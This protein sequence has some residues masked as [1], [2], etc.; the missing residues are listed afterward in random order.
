MASKTDVI[1][2]LLSRM[3]LA[4]KIGQLNLVTPG[5]ETLTGSVVNTGVAE[6][7]KAGRIGSIFGVKSPAAVRALQ[8]LALQSRLAIPLMF[9]E[10]VVHGH[11]TIFPIPIG[12]AATWNLSLIEET[13]RIAAV[14]AT[15]GGIDQVYAPVVD[16]C[17]DPR[18]GRMAESPGE[19]P[20]LASRYA[21]AMV[22]GFQ[23]DDLS[24]PDATMACLKHFAAYGAAAAGRDYAGADMSPMRL[25]DVYLPPFKAGVEAGAGSIMAGF[26]TLNGVPMHANRVLIEEV[27][28]G[29]FGF[30]GLVVSDY[31]GVDELMGHQMAASH[32]EA[33]RAAV[34]AGVD[35]DMV[36]ESYLNTLQASVEAGLLDA[37]LIEA[38]CRRVLEAKAKLGLFDDP[39]RRLKAGEPPAEL[40][41]AH[42]AVARRAAADA[43]VL[44]KNEG[45]VLPLS[46]SAKVALVGPLTNDRVNMNGTWAVSGRSSDAVT[47]L[48]GFL[49][50]IGQGGGIVCARGC[51]IVDDP[52]LA[53]RL[54]VHDRRD[55]SVSIDPRTADVLIAEAIA[56]AEAA[57]V[58]VAVLGESKEYSGESSSRADLRLSAGQRRLVADLKQTGKPLVLVILAGRALVITEEAATADAVVYAWFGGT[59]TGHGLADLLYG[60]AEPAGRLP[61]TLPFHEGQVP[62]AYGEPKTGRPYTGRFEKFRTGYLDLPDGPE[63][64]DGLFPFGFGLSYSAVRYGPVTADRTSLSGDADRAVIS[65]EVRNDG[66]RPAVDVV[67]LYVGAPVSPISRPSRR[68]VQFE[69]LVL[70]P[71][72]ARTVS[73]A[74][75]AADLATSVAEHVAD[76]RRDWHGGAFRVFL[77]ANSRA[78]QGVDLIWT[79]DGAVAV[80]S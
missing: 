40:P 47:I 65:C 54:N 4:E 43:C 37:S 67:Q 16:V 69:R 74:I 58:V 66:D 42:R 48:D 52:V 34:K 25:H 72:E 56:A 26:N 45:G 44:L 18:W 39:Y 57:D 59:E 51:N 9:A 46:R 2:D 23:G 32:A 41:S 21:E 62:I 7:V 53:D 71:G 55:L 10:D 28:R 6:K 75:T 63:Q 50:A 77:G 8:D 13:A 33:A 1:D 30:D 68:L 61:V 78:E 64:I 73:F 17:R 79:K 38:A 60:D 76:C 70:A 14:E 19:D 36:G 15:A 12:M 27:L 20:V 22:R 49:E 31:T 80:T 11:R 3:T 35:L 29:R 24:R 5:G